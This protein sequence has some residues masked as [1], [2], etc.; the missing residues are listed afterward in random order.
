[1]AAIIARGGFES[2]I[3]VAARDAVD[4]YEAVEHELSKRRTTPQG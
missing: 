2:D 4:L 3:P 1:M